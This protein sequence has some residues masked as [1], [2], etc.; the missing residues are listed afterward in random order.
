M[1][2]LYIDLTYIYTSIYSACSSFSTPQYGFI[3]YYFNTK[4]Y[5][6]II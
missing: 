3:K 6:N 4:V 2:V 1:S 5:F